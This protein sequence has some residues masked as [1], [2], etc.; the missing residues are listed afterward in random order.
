MHWSDGAPF[1]AD[2]FLFWY[3]D[4]YGNEELVPTTRSEMTINGEPGSMEKVDEYTVLF[5]FPD[6]YYLLPD[7]L[8][9]HTALGGQ[10]SQGLSALGGYAPAH[11]LKQ[12]HPDYAEA[13]DLN[14]QVEEAEVES[15]VDLFTLKNDWAL[16]PELPVVSPWKTVTPINTTTWTLE[17][18]P[19]SVWVDTDGNQ[20]PYIGEIVMTLAEDLEVLN[21]RTIA[22]EYDFQ[23]RHVDMAKLPVLLENEEKGGY[24]VYLDPGEYGSDMV[25]NFNL[26]YQKDPE[27]AKWFGNTDFRRALSLGIER[28]QLNEIFWLGTGTPGSPAPSDTNPYSPGE[29]YRTLWHTYDPERANALLDEI[30]LDQ[31][32]GEGFRLRTDGQDRLRL[33]LTSYAAAFM[34]YEQI[35]EVIAQQWTEIGIDLAVRPME[36]SA[37][38]ALVDTN[39]HQL[40]AWTGDGSEHLFTYPLQ[41]FPYGPGSESGPLYGL[42]FQSGGSQGLEPPMWL[43]DLYTKFR[44][45]FGVP[46]DERAELGKEIW[47]IVVDNVLKIGVVGLSPANMGVRVVKT[48]MGNIPARQFNSPA[49]KT[50]SVSRPMT[51][52]FKE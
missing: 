45:A 50:P 41:A 24:E 9:G 34:P 27:I 48:T 35:A 21:L 7:V 46:E 6:P 49:V 15:W 47:E 52:F 39:E 37:A 30:G 36:R 17:R 3:Q 29:E 12:F 22:G 28:D 2:D 1:T 16:N 4:M 44:K 23:A 32:D 42:W 51:F 5:R 19:Y 31:K 10:A 11:Y 43:Q 26:S 18:N 38:G 33:D 13:S 40:F 20:L 25:I 8:A 14:R